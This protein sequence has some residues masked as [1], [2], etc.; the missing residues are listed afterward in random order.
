[1]SENKIINKA[2]TTNTKRGNITSTALKQTTYS[3][4]EYTI[5]IIENYAREI[6]ISAFNFRTMEFYITQFIDNEAYVNTLTMINYWRPLEIIMNQK[7]ESSSLHLLL[8][9]LFTNCYI[10]FQPRKAFN[11]DNGKVIYNKSTIKELSHDEM[12][13]KYVCMASLSGLIS[14]LETN[15]NYIISDTLV[16]HYHYLE[17]HLNISFNSTIDLELLINKKHNKTNILHHYGTHL[18]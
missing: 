7:S 14:Y 10:G 5:S 17:N 13:M 12:N 2:F 11:E 4:Q 9:N 1:M 8:K 6:G 16:I 15:P 18:L 3:E